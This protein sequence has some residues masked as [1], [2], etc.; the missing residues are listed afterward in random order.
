MVSSNSATNI[1][2][3][4]LVELSKDL[5]KQIIDFYRSGKSLGATIKQLQIPKSPNRQLFVGIKCMVSLP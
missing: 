4:K 5:K 3:G 2:A 1:R